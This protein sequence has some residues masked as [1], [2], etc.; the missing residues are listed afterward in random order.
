MIRGLHTAVAF[1]MMLFASANSVAADYPQRPIHLIVGAAPGGGSDFVARTVGAKVST[2]LGQ[3]IIVEN[4]GGAA[5]LV[6]SEFVAKTPADGYT[7]LVVF[8]NYATFPSLQKHLSFDPT[9]DLVPVSD[10][11]TSPLVLT[12]SPSLP[13]KSVND[14][15]AYAKGKSLNYAS[16]GVGS[17]GHLAAELFQSMAGIKMTHVPY[18]GGGPAII[19]LLGGQVDVYFS[20]PAAAVAQMKAGKLH[21]LAVTGATRAGFA[22]EL[23]TIA[24]SGLKGYEVSGWFGI[25]APAG[26]PQ[27]VIDV[28]SR[29]IAT[30]V[31]DPGI[32][33]ALAKDGDTPV[34]NSPSEFA[35]EVHADMEKWGKVIKDGHIELE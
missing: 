30:A 34:G 12:V 1:L 25:F 10:I 13:V 28:V 29:A 4:R 23:P 3:S 9:K 8:A 32:R 6:A 17:M 15:V 5:G 31:K 16:P 22:P 35:K 26:T 20:T 14:L 33:D 21:A 19:G 18:R 2:L 7:L 27:P 11:A 24:E